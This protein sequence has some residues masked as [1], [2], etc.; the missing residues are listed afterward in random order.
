VQL[1]TLASSADP[2]SSVQLACE[3]W[4]KEQ[5]RRVHGHVAGNANRMVELLSDVQHNF[6]L[7]ET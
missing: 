5:Q 3:R 6:V 1:L 2:T 4:P 7:H